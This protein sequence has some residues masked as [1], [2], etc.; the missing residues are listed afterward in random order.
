MMPSGNISREHGPLIARGLCC[1]ILL[2]CCGCGSAR[3]PVQ[4]VDLTGEPPEQL[5]AYGLFVGNGSA[6][7]PVA[8]V[9]PYDLNSAL[10]SDY[11]HKYRFVRMPK[12]TSAAYHATDVFS[13][14]V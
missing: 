8:G 3:L 9:V 2:V 5:S 7:E 13:F 1:F 14:P 6:Q 10:F 4:E 11:A 12:G